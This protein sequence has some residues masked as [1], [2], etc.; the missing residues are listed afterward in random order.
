MPKPATTIATRVQRIAEIADAYA[1]MSGGD[2][3]DFATDLL[4]DLQHWCE[5]HGVRFATSLT[6]ARGHFTADRG[7]A[8]S[9]PQFVRYVRQLREDGTAAPPLGRPALASAPTA[10][11]KPLPTAP[12]DPHTSTCS[13]QWT[14]PCPA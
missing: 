8:I 4:T 5:A 7:D 9:S 3:Q 13:P 6:Y 10:P 12:E 11:I 1:S 2:P 14:N